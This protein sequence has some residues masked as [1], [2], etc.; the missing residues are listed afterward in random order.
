MRVTRRAFLVAARA[1]PP[2]A[3]LALL[4]PAAAAAQA[5]REAE[6][7]GALLRVEHTSVF[8]Y[9]HVLRG[10]T[11]RGAQAR[12][13]GTLRAHEARHAAALEK[14]LRDMGWPLPKPPDRLE[15]VE[16]PQ[17][18]LALE[19]DDPRGALT[20]LER[21]SD[22]V[23]RLGLGRLRSGPHVQLAATIL[24]AEAT[25]RVAWRTVR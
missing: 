6:A 15:R 23:Y 10:G 21:L 2:A 8:A 4:R 3:A 1:A 19:G 22:E 25:H 11:L 17:V 16:V 18:R 7:L 20:E 14:A 13:A 12:L 5:A 24:A 9:E